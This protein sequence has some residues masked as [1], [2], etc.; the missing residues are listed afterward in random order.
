[1]LLDIIQSVCLC[2]K[3]SFKRKSSI[4]FVISV[5]RSGSAPKVAPV[6]NTS[7][8][9][10]S[11]FLVSLYLRSV[12]FPLNMG[13]LYVVGRLQGFHCSRVFQPG[14]FSG[15]R[16]MDVDARYS[17]SGYKSSRYNQHG[18]SRATRNTLEIKKLTILTFR[19]NTSDA[20][21]SH[22]NN[23]VRH[24][25]KVQFRVMLSFFSLNSTLDATKLL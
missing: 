21:E 23:T 4:T 16:G 15:R 13:T 3:Q 24:F 22:R 6:C 25:I 18:V 12:L 7:T 11:D 19:C 20:Q 9:E 10:A 5:Q 2:W 14:F 1:M 8:T 17:D